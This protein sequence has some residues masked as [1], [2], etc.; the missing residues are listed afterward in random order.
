M[1]SGCILGYCKICDMPVHEDEFRLNRRDKII[2]FECRETSMQKIY[3]LA[4]D[5]LKGA[6]KEG[7]TDEGVLKLIKKIAAQNI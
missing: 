4:D 2:H 1:P 5:Q 3:R 6:N 7:T